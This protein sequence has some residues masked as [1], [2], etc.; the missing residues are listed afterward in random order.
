MI[1][2]MGPLASDGMGS[3][4][5][6][7]RRG[8]ASVGGSSGREFETLACISTRTLSSGPTFSTTTHTRH[9]A[10]AIEHAQAINPGVTGVKADYVHF[11]E[12]SAPLA[13]NETAVLDRLLTYGPAPQPHDVCVCVCVCVC[14][15]SPLQGLGVRV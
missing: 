4:V 11:V 14:V 6:C 12:L 2:R 5:C 9:H 3:N 10:H 13:Q 15:R 1:A 7:G 8:F